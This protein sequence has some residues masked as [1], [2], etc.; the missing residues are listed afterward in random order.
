VT[1]IVE[2]FIHPKEQ[3]EVVHNGSEYGGLPYYFDGGVDWGSP[4]MLIAPTFSW[5]YTNPAKYIKFDFK[6]LSMDY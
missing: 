5:Y 1:K 2:G 3:K 4:Q 6:D